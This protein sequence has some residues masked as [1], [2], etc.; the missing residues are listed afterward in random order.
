M[1]QHHRTDHLTTVTKTII[2]TF[3]YNATIKENPVRNTGQGAPINIATSLCSV[4]I[5]E[6]TQ[7]KVF[8]SNAAK[9]F[10]KLETTSRALKPLPRHVNSSKTTHVLHR[11]AL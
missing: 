3:F 1:E 5:R 6:L 9:H 10:V 7:S 4:S 8:A 2:T 11:R